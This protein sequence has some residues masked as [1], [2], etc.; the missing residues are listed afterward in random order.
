MALDVVWQRRW[1]RE[2][3]VAAKAAYRPI[4]ASVTWREA[5]P[6]V[7]LAGTGVVDLTLAGGGLREVRF[8]RGL[9]RLELLDPNRHLAVHAADG[10]TKRAEIDALLTTATDDLRI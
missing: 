9:R 5:P 10:G 3:P 7:D 2:L 6:V 4:I 1:D 8:P